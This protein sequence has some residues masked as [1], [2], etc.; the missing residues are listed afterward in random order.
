MKKKISFI[1][2]VN[3]ESKTIE[4][5]ISDILKIK[6][7]INFELIVVQDGSK[8]GTFEILNK[9]SKKKKI[10]LFNKKK[11]LGYY[12][13]FLK[14]IELSKGEIIFFSDTGNKYDYKK[15]IQL[16]KIFK[17]KNADLIS[18]Y[19]VK[20]QD[21]ILRQLLTFFYTILINLI[22]FKRYKDYDCGFK[23]FNK[24]KL[25]MILKKY[26]FNKNLI[27]SQV[28]L[29]FI[30]HNFR[31]FQYPIIYKEKKNRNSRGLPTN[32]VF[33]I[34]LESILNLIKIKLDFKTF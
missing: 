10:T 15:F 25:L 26:K 6:K 2:L 21:K 29:Y 9:I 13:A 24:K 16:Y 20:R 34:A 22:F 7:K 18:C 32:K 23:I 8:D 11:R 27:T 14:G 28:F 19:R 12:K 5:E 1:I 17:E 4:N 33:K 3:N 30:K 31:I